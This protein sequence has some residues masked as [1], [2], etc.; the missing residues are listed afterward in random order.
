VAGT[1]AVA[2][3]ARQAAPAASEE[4]LRAYWS[5]SAVALEDDFLEAVWYR[6][7]YF[8][9]C[10]VRP[11]AAC[12]GL[13]ANWSYG[14]IG[15]EWHGDYPMNYNTQQPFWV[16]FSSN[17]VDKHLA[18]ANMVDHVLP[19]SRKWAKEYYGLRGTYYPH[20]A[21][22]VEMTMMPYPLPHWGREVC[23]TPWNVQSLWWHYLYTMDKSFLAD[24]AFVPIKEAVLFMVDYMKRPEVSGEAWGDDR[25]HIFPTVVPEL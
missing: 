11:D 12:P 10:A 24:R 16:A 25:Y 22:P 3:P 6:N 23:E 2:C 8:F 7:L 21:Y 1:L 20:S 4:K 9:Q 13:F 15:A 18:Y 14:R 19:V 5:R 17:H